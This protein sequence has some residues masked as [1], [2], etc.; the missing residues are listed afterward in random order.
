M[1]ACCGM[2]GG[3]RPRHYP[4]RWAVTWA[5]I[6]TQATT[7][8]SQSEDHGRENWK[9]RHY[10]SGLLVQMDALAVRR[11]GLRR[12]RLETPS[13]LDG[14]SGAIGTTYPTQGGRGFW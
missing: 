14:L 5:G 1:S 9:P 12:F 7:D 11:D 10:R 4:L 2:G 13:A 8:G 6:G 3:Q